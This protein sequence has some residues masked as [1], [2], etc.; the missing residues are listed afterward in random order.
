M[1]FAVDA[2]ST[3]ICE[4]KNRS[5][6]SRCCLTFYFILFTFSFIHLFSCYIFFFLCFTISPFSLFLF[7]FLFLVILRLVFS[8]YLFL[9]LFLILFLLIWA[10]VL[11]VFR[12]INLLLFS[13]LLLTLL[14]VAI[15]QFV[16]VHHLIVEILERHSDF[17]DGACNKLG[18]DEKCV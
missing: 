10:P 17:I 9:L 6:P 7:I 5:S 8:Q 1:N 4:K 16:P 18:G 2:R 12:F 13:F 11:L 14:R 15:I 3:V